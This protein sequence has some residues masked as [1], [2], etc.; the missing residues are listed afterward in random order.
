MHGKPPVAA[1]EYGN[2]V[3]FEFLDYSLRCAEAGGSFA[4][5]SRGSGDV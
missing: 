3:V 4:W 2:Q 1:A 5:C